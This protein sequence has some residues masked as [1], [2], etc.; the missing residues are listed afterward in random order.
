[1]KEILIKEYNNLIKNPIPPLVKKNTFKLDFIKGCKFEVL[2]D[3]KIKYVVN[4]INQDNGEIVYESIITNNMWCKS[5]IQ[6]FVNY[7]VRVKNEDTDEVVFEHL[8]NAQNQ[9][10]YIH[11]A[12]SALGD[13]LSWMPHLEEFK[14]IHNC[15]LTVSTFHNEMF[16]SVYP[17]LTFV[18]PGIELFDLY[19]MYEVGW[20]YD[21]EEKIDYS[22]NPLNFRKQ[23]LSKT[24]T[25]ILGLNYK[26]IKPKH[27]FKNTGPTVD[28][29]YICIAPHAS[30]HAKYWNYE[31]GW[32]AVVDYI[33][34]IG[35]KAVI[36]TKEP[37]GNEWD[38][39]KLGGTLTNVIDK[40]GD[41]PLS[42]RAND[43]MNAKAFIG[44]GS[45]LSWLSWA[46]ECPTILISG[47]SES[48][49]E[50]EDCIRITPPKNKCS[51]CFNFEKLDAGDWEW[52]PEH[53]GSPRQFECTKSILPQTIIDAIDYQLGNIS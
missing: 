37:L 27:T 20:H 19:A 5:N 36:I 44:L 32:Q 16:E 1:M 18:K 38:D 6:Y 52:C 15:N 12:S 42:E 43:L 24:A 13:T 28:G 25:D 30:S 14:K 9:K 49:S 40:T 3:E 2:G 46:V 26:E 51:G 34:S 47:F 31:G 10:I 45:G 50:F 7:L 4:F 33:N 41:F 48:Y 39:S 23:P 11:L 8:Y 21:E 53:K 35:Y 17:N 29:D 22:K